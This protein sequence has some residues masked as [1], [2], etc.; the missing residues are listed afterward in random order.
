MDILRALSSGA[1]LPASPASAAARTS[2]CSSSQISRSWDT[3]STVTSEVRSVRHR[4]DVPSD[5][6]IKWRHVEASRADFL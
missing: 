2:L 1:T 3:S 5:G 6:T 4:L